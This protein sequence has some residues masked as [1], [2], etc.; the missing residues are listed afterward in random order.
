[1][2]VDVVV[3]AL[4]GRGRSGQKHFAEAGARLAAAAHGSG[5]GRAVML[6]IAQ[7]DQ[8]PMG[9][10][11][12]RVA[13]EQVYAEAKLPTAVV[14][15]SQ[16]HSLLD[17]VFRAGDR[18]RMVPS[19]RS[20]WFQP[21][22]VR[23]VAR[24]LVDAAA[25]DLHGHTVRTVSGPERKPLTDFAEEWRAATGSRARVVELPLP[26]RLGRYFAEGRNVAPGTAFGTITFAQ[27]L[28]ERGPANLS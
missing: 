26:G 13:K 2:G 4:N 3:D 24:A 19:V 7:C 25:E 27:W 5:V 1:D 9:Y 14:R 8:L 12:A 10:Y 22:D 17:T 28:A 21:I 20:A 6:S 15:A 23:D 18:I 16:F 11:R